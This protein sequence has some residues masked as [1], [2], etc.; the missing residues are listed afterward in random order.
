MEETQ[1]LT[2]SEDLIDDAIEGFIKKVRGIISI[3]FQATYW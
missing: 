3:G 2:L 1:A